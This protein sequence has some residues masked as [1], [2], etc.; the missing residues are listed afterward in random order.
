MRLGVGAGSRAA[1]QCGL[2]AQAGMDSMDGMDRMDGSANA[3]WREALL[4]LISAFCFFYCAGGAA[5][6]QN[7][8]FAQA[9]NL[10]VDS[11]LQ[12]ADGAGFEPA[13]PFRGTRAF[14]ARPFDHSGTHP[15]S[16]PGRTQS[17]PAAS[18][19]KIRLARHA[20][21]PDSGERKAES[22]V[23]PRA[24]S[25]ESPGVARRS[26]TPGQADEEVNPEIDAGVAPSG[27]RRE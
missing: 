22:R 6:L 16:R 14:Q 19:Q 3:Q 9:S 27:V 21:Q 13:V 8:G 24:P 2:R 4:R 23:P 10:A 20:P 5:P 15:G 25:Y 7:A 17:S 26:R 11:C 18:N 12:L 1:T